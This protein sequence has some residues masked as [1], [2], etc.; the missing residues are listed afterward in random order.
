MADQKI[1]VIDDEPRFAA[2]L[3]QILSVSEGFETLIGD[4][5]IDPLKSVETLLPD[6]VIVSSP[7]LKQNWIELG[8][9]IIRIHPSVKVIMLSP[10]PTDEELLEVLK[11]GAAALVNKNTPGELIINIKRALHGE[12]PINEAVFSRPALAKRILTQFQ[13]VEYI[14]EIS[15]VVAPVTERETEILNFVAAGHSNKQIA[16]ALKISEQTIKN[17]VSSIL[18]KLNANDRAH[19]VVLALRKG[20]LKLN[21][22]S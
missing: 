3:Q 10:E 2:N 13:N 18:R 14:E 21:G 19:A 17:H 11:T 9:K 16:A 6:V 5:R 12:Y 8:K 22:A 15:E 7:L 1:L 4:S 20:Y